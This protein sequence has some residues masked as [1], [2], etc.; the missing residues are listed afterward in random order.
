[1]NRRVVITGMG[2]VAPNGHGLQE[3][4]EALRQG[5]SGIRFIPELKAL[6]FAC[7]VAGVPQ[8]FEEVRNRYFDEEKIMSINANIG[9]ASVAAVDAWRDAGF[10]VSE[11]EDVDWDSGVIVGSGIG[12]MDTIGRTGRAARDRGEDQE[13]RQQ[14]RR[15]GHEQR[16]QRPHR[17]FAGPRQ[18]GNVELLGLQHRDR[19]HRGRDV[20]DPNGT[21]KKDPGPEAP[22]ALRPTSGQDL[23]PCG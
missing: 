22:K 5:R 4:E 20:A 8:N 13:A 18:P 9:Y 1:M 21:R 19:G 3:F 6:N 12:G 15:T 10:E 14:D 17:R 16:D 7:Q 2:V 11:G 23:I